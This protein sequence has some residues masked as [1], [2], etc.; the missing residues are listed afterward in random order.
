[1]FTKDFPAGRLITIDA[2]CRLFIAIIFI[3]VC[4]IPFGNLSAQSEIK[5]S[6]QVKDVAT[7]APIPGAAVSL[8]GTGKYA[9]SDAMGR[10]YFVD[11]LSGD[12]SVK[13]ERIGYVQNT[14]VTA[15]PGDA[16]S[17]FVN[18]GMS[19]VPV[20]VEGQT[21]TGAGGGGYKIV[22]SAGITTVEIPASGIRS[23][24]EFT[25]QVPEVELVES[26]P[27]KFLRIRGAGLNATTVMLDGRAINSVLD[28]RGD[29]S[30]IPLGSVVKVEIAAGGH[31]AGGL[32]GSVN[33]ITDAY[34][35]NSTS[36]ASERGSFGRE[37]YSIG[38]GYRSMRN[39][40]LTIEARSEFF[41]GD[42][43]FTDPRDSM[44]SRINNYDRA[45]KLFGALAYTWN[46]RSLR[47][48]C[49]FFKR[50]AGVPGPIFQPTPE[51]SSGSE[52][53]EAYSRFE[54]K[55]AKRAVFDIA[56]GITRRHA[57]FD[58]PRTPTNFIPYK[59]RF[60][61]QSRDIKFGLGSTGKV[62]LDA[63]L[64]LRY[65]SL[66]GKDLLRPSSS[67]GFRSRAINTISA[68]MVYHFL[69]V[70]AAAES[71]AIAFGYR[72]EWG[73]QGDYSMPSAALRMNF[74]LPFNPGVD[75]S[76]SR[77]RR[78]PDLTDLYWKEDVFATPNPELN[79]ERSENFQLGADLKGYPAGPFSLRATRYINRYK[80]LIIWRKWAG[81]KFKPVNVSKAEIDGWEFAFEADPFSGP[82]TL[83]WT[84]SFSRPLN[85]EEEQSHRGKYLTFRPIDVQTAI[86]RLTYKN[87]DLKFK[88]RHIG[89]RYT[90][91]ENTKSLPAVD[92][93]DFNFEYKFKIKSTV[94]T[95]G[96]GITNIGNIQYEI[97][98]RQPEKPRE[99]RAIIEFTPK[100]VF[101]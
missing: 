98:D 52:E 93:L 97:L 69:G 56:G 7:G 95:V 85:R 13:A 63:N 9:V 89:K 8:E 35:R 22:R 94:T 11:L 10:F 76:F 45:Q 91:E 72:N 28:S 100:G 60:D 49:R 16:Y 62:D 42:F 18:I 87:F 96:L 20:Y 21:V 54:M 26:G 83:N 31:R 73:K 53:Y 51:A 23:I 92:L 81:D 3:I 61:E 101:R 2:P 78:L 55:S 82:L 59:S 47:L 64:S 84:A 40:G 34:K 65:E 29:I 25:E 75:L 12:Y 17:I 66:D 74:G 39:L 37:I 14:P 19:R 77:G 30:V 38:T 70:L 32:A 4:L 44:Q 80:D 24:G 79:P 99:Y 86:A 67:F 6:G 68:G 57:E 41:R 27:R 48:N 71:S 1:M 5:I 90:T 33:F 15:S 88:S 58:S 50:K 46:G 43:T 36:I